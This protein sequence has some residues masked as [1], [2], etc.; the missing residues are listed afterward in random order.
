M[1]EHTALHICRSPYGHT[2]AERR[3]A[4]LKV[5][6]LMESYKDAYL[7][8]RQFAEDSGLDTTTYG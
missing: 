2:A 6:E 4:R 3:E 5:C 7:N 8:M 1:T